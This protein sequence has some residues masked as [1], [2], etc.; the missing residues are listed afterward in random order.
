MREGGNVRKR[1]N[2]EQREYDGIEEAVLVAEM[3]RDEL[4]ATL[5][6]GAIFTTD[7]AQGAQM[8]EELQ[9]LEGEIE[10]LYARWQELEELRES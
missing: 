3:R 7:P 4:A 2:K 9:A 1:T 5:A 10:R 8:G 6:D